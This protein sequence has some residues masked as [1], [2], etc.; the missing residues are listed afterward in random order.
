MYNETVNLIFSLSKPLFIQGLN[1][2]ESRIKEN[3][4]IFPFLVV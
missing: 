4:L 1:V 2:G 3:A